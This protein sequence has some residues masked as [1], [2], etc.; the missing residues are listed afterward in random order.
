MKLIKLLSILFAHLLYLISPTYIIAQTQ[1]LAVAPGIEGYGVTTQGGRGGQI[2]RVTNLYDTGAG[3]LR[4]ALTATEPRI[5]IFEVSGVIHLSTK[6]KI[7]SPYITVA[8]QTAPSPG[9]IIAGEPLII[10]THDVYLS[11]LTIRVG[12][13]GTTAAAGRD[14]IGMQVET[15]GDVYNIVIDH[16]SVSWAVDENIAISAGSGQIHDITV[17]NSIISEGLGNADHPS[18]EHSKGLLVSDHS[19]NIAVIKNLFAHNMRRNPSI[20]GDSTSLVLNNLVY[21]PGIFSIHV[22]DNNGTGLVLTNIIGNK[23]ISGQDTDSAS[24]DK[25]YIQNNTNPGSQIYVSNNYPANPLITNPILNSTLYSTPTIPLPAEINIFTNV[26]LESKILQTSG[27]RSWDRDTTDQRII[28][29]IQNNSGSIIDIPNSVLGIHPDIVNW[30]EY[31]PEYQKTNLRTLN[32][33]NNPNNDN[34]LNGYT[35]LEEWLNDD[36]Y[37]QDEIASLI[38][39]SNNDELVNL[40]DYNNFIA[41]ITRNDLRSDF[42][43]SGTVEIFDYNIL[44]TNF[45]NQ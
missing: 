30:W 4:E 41:D 12:S 19:K 5:V 21:N 13:I 33:P 35:N 29:E 45:I 2:Y 26:E 1:N 39:D 20:F 42:N 7:T 36:V 17:S 6:L 31:L 44:V 28:N 38:G 34:D 37:W 32:I 24:G 43:N 8:G 25:I 15:F 23:I 16:V 40:P 10:T 14:G 9:I 3:S 11:N 18:G 27:A 22:N